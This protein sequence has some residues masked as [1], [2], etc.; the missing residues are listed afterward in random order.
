[1]STML[2]L[3]KLE[4]NIEELA[5]D[6]NGNHVIQKCIEVVEPQDL[7][8]ILDTFRNKVRQISNIICHLLSSVF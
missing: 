6:Q 4:S 1:M 8:F 3:Q 5:C 7:Q 2:F